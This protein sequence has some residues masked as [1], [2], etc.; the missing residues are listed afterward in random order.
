MAMADRAF[1]LLEEVLVDLDDLDRLLDLYADPEPDHQAGQPVSI[2]E[3]DPDVAFVD[4][5]P[6]TTLWM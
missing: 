6:S 3:N 5:R 1:G 2:G 4:G